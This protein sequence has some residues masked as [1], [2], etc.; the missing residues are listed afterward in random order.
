MNDDESPIIFQSSVY[1]DVFLLKFL[2]VFS[3][4]LVSGLELTAVPSTH[5]S[6]NPLRR[7]DVATEDEAC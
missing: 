5:L 6:V 4:F 3:T 2:L 7:R 1:F